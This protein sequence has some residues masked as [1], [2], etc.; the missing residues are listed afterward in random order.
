M[1][2]S[3]AGSHL[4]RQHWAHYNDKALTQ[5]LFAHYNR[6]FPVSDHDRLFTEAFKHQLANG[7]SDSFQS[8]LAESKAELAA[9]TVDQFDLRQRQRRFI[10][11]GVDLVRSQVAVRTPFCDNDLVEFMLTVPP[12]LRLDRYLFIKALI[13]MFPKLAKIPW[14]ATGYPLSLCA[15]DLLLR[16]NLQIRWWLRNRG[17]NQVPIPGKKPYA[18]YNPWM[19]T[20]LCNWVEETLLSQ[21]ALERG[22]FNPDCIRNLVAEQKA[23]ANHASKLGVLLALE[24]WHRQNIDCG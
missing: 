23:G 7:V 4:N 9:N 11:T 24:L 22:Y 8:A 2:D 12:G 16:S 19:R 13:R 15:R 21:P 6:I 3:L 20:A 1:G 10:L 18:N 14:E 17:F 5:M